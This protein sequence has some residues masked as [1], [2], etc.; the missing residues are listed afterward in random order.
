MVGRPFPRSYDRYR[1]TETRASRFSSND[2]SRG[3]SFRVSGGSDR[4]RCELL[5]FFNSLKGLE[6]S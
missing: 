6:D 2:D 3:R 4:K 5:D 1:E